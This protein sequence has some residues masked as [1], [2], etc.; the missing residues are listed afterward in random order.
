MEWRVWEE[1]MLPEDK[2]LIP[3]VIAHTTAVVEHPENSQNTQ[4]S[5]SA[6]GKDGPPGCKY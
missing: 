5:I 3:G 1:V 4:G 6:I 2:M